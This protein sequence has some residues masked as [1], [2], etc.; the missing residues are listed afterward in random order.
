[1]KSRTFTRI[2]FSCW[3]STAACMEAQSSPTPA[4]EPEEILLSV[5]PRETKAPSTKTT[6]VVP[7]GI[8][9]DRSST[10]AKAVPKKAAAQPDIADL[11]A[12]NGHTCLASGEGKVVC[13]GANMAGQLGSPD[14]NL[15]MGLAVVP[16]IA[17]AIEISAGGNHTCARRRSGEV[18]CWGSGSTG[19][20]GD[21]TTH[22]RRTPVLVRGITD[23]RDL[24]TGESHS[25]A[26]RKK[27]TGELL[28]QQ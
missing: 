11:S 15:Q 3:L 23:A 7:K 2:C 24:A 10:K 16:G 13:W 28:G 25:C 8:A 20:L 22:S 14:P 21:G 26:L 1:M 12:G 5:K 17:D 19:A 9:G 27:R 18:W 4:R 6:V